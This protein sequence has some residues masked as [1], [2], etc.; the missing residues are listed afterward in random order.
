MTDPWIGRTFEGCRL[1]A[2]IAASS[3][4]HLY[5]ATDVARGEPVSVALVHPAPHRRLPDPHQVLGVH[6]VLQRHAHPSIATVHH[7]AMVEGQLVLVM[8]ALR[9]ET[10][11]HAVRR[12]PLSP[13]AL[14]QLAHELAA[15]ANHLHSNRLVHGHLSPH[16][17]LLTPRG[18]CLLELGTADPLRQKPPAADIAAIGY[19]LYMAATGRAGTQTTTPVGQL[20]PMVPTWLAD[21]IDDCRSGD[22][23]RRPANGAALQAR[24]QTRLEPIRTRSVD[25]VRPADST[26]FAAHTQR[27]AA[28]GPDPTVFLKVPKRDTPELA[29]PFQ[30]E[31][32]P[33]APIPP[34]TYQPPPPPPAAPPAAPAPRP[35]VPAPAPEPAPAPAPP[36]T[37]TPPAPEPAPAPPP[38]K[39]RSGMS[40]ALIGVAVGLVVI[41]AVAGVFGG[42]WWFS[43][44]DAGV[45][46]ATGHTG[47]PAT[48]T[49]S[50]TGSA[51]TPGPVAYA[52][53]IDNQGGR[54][55]HL[56]CS[57][58]ALDGSTDTAGNGP[59]LEEALLNG[60]SASAEGV[61]TGAR[62]EAQEP[63]SGDALW[64]WN[65][66]GAPDDDARWTIEITG[67]PEPEPVARRTTRRP[68]RTNAEPA[69][70][71]PRPSTPPPPEPDLPAAATLRVVPGSKRKKKQK[72]VEV[73]VDGR[74]RGTAPVTVPELSLGA[75]RIEATREGEKVACV[76]TLEEGGLTVAV[77]PTKGL[78]AKQ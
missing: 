64:T 9:G 1:D 66:E 43:Q 62:C 71:R 11:Q 24:V 12:G 41:L 17:V 10:L 4:A 21:L 47:T 52:L 8:D 34:R 39:A 56:S 6:R 5:R 67:L 13:N 37:P 35:P 48:G 18:A 36:V 68:R 14:V 75:H 30:P 15:A 74:K 70:H 32:V 7:A 22:P 40:A 19:C 29:E 69:P 26:V 20:A 76:I 28:S 58:D 45:A 77:D 2:R 16:R 44:N 53:T 54:P 72:G 78:C 42:A 50:D 25:A 63:S 73:R 38:P 3:S 61:T 46:E 60:E 55:V 59:G 33:D 31:P 57:W 23:N 49:A 65:A 51:G 27:V